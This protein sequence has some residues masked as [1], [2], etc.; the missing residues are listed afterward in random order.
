M[1]EEYQ[2]ALEVIFAYGYGCCVF[3]YNICGDCPNV[4]E[5]MPDS[6]DSLPPGFF[7]NLGCPSVQAITEAPTIKVPEVAKEPAE[8]TASKD[9]VAAED[10]G[11][12]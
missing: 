9:H 3:K 4:S 8:I 11:K 1:K 5:G 12:L 10:H 7:V 2:K 6:A